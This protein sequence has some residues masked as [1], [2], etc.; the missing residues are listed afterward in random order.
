MDDGVVNRL[1]RFFFRAPI[2][3]YR[4]GLGGLM[5]D[6][7]LLL[8]HVGRKSG[9]TRSTV[10]EVL[11]TG[12]DGV[13]VVAS[14]FGESSQWFKNVTA[15]PAVHTTRGRTRTAASA[16]RLDHDDALDVFERYRVA[17]PRAAKVLGERI[18]VSLVDDLDRAADELPLF[19]LE[20]SG[21]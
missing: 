18:G 16:V 2:G 4:I 11:E 8:E 17:H 7:F 3:L 6:R 10:L 19:R 14:G 20:P 13:P 21:G 5:G 12:Q 1:Q 9:E 15:N